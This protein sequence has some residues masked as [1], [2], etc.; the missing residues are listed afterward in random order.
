MN[1][2]V[3]YMNLYA[4]YAC[5]NELGTPEDQTLCNIQNSKAVFDTKLQAYEYLYNNSYNLLQSVY[6][7]K[8]KCPKG[9]L[10]V[11]EITC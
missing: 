1:T 5:K 7:E 10:Y 4:I 11:K 6:P 9:R 8:W 3:N 2:I